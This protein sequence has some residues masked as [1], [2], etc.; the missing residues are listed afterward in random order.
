MGHSI[1]VY[2]A[3]VE[4]AVDPITLI[5]ENGVV[6]YQNPASA[7]YFGWEPEDL[8]GTNIFDHLHP[9]DLQTAVDA[10]E[11][12]R[13]GEDQDRIVVRFRTKDD[14]WRI[15]EVVA[16][17][18]E[19]NGRHLLILNTRDVTEREH[20]EEQLRQSQRI[21]AFGQLTSGI[22]HDFNNML[23][24]I[25]GHVELGLNRYM[26]EKQTRESFVAIHDAALRG[27][28]HIEQLMTFSRTQDLN[29]ERFAAGECVN[30][31]V[32]LIGHTLGSQIEIEVHGNDTWQCNVDRRLLENAILNM[33]INARDAMPQG[34][35]LQ[36]VTRDVR[37]DEESARF[38]DVESGDYIGLEV[39][40]TGTGMS[41]ETQA[42]V[43][44][45]FYTTK[46][47]VG[48][49]GLGMSMVF[50]FVRQSLG[51]IRIESEPGNG[52]TISLFLPRS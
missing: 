34:G 31:M 24:I 23:T 16:S 39:S 14:R 28:D 41:E 20:F 30:D 12:I 11:A 44:E 13:R 17:D 40:D 51:H 32:K 50:G 18:L 47:A 19:E 6:I 2:E 15:V 33:S 37:V 45:P 48:G 52:T 5:D 9:N 46:P 1:S 36:I 4:H 38:M 7:V 21:E 26:D 25:R 29:P 43:F 42:R 10:Y 27:S 3:L 49:T 22:V 8:L 35:R